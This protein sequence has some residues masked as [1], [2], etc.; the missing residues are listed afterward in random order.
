MPRTRS[1]AWSELKIGVLTSVALAIAAVAIFT[2]T[3]TKGAFWQ[4]YHLK[5]RFPNAI[6]LSVGSPVRIA[7]VEVGLVRGIEITGEEVDLSLEVNKEHR[8]QITTAS[9]ARLGSISLLGE[10]AVDITPSTKGT[11]LPDWGYVTP[12]RTPKAF[13]DIAD[14]ASEGST[15]STDASRR[16]GGQG[17]RRK[18]MTDERLYVE[19]QQFVATAGQ[20]TREL[21]QGRGTLGKL[22]KDP[23]AAEPGGVGQERRGADAAHQRRR[24]QPRQAAERRNVLAVVMN[25]AAPKTNLKELTERLNRGEGTA[26]KLITDATLFNRLNSVTERFDQLVMK[27]NDG[28][29]TA[30]RLLKDRQLYENMNGAVNDLRA[31]ITAISKDP[32]KYLNVK[33][34][35]F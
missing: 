10:G 5:T 4:R 32:K 11:P 34:S 14:Q 13:A 28:E 6:G 8:N 25:P 27:L 22:L 16:A 12:G 18:F 20:M 17:H 9:V 31:L 19:L 2:L 1:L 24:R 15:R 7:G 23:K 21:K 33:V 29:G 3:G 26:G 35:I 30:G